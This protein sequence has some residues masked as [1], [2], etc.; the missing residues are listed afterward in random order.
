MWPGWKHVSRGVTSLYTLHKIQRTTSKVTDNVNNAN[1]NGGNG[2]GGNNGCSYK[3]FLACNTQDYD[4]KGGAVA[5]TRWIEKMELV[6]ENSRCAEN[7]KVEFKVLLV[8]EFCP[9]NKMEK[10]E[11][12]FWNHTLVGANHAGYNDRF[13]ELAKLVPHLVTPESKRIGRYISGLAPQI[14]GMLRATQPTTIQSAILKVGILTDEAVCYECG[15]SKHLRNTCP[16]LN[17]APGQAGNRLALEGNRNTQNNRNQARGRV[18]SM[19]A[20]DAL[21]D[22]NI[23]MGTFSLND[24]FA[25]V[26]FDSGADFSFISTKFAPLLNVKPSIVSP[27]YVIE[28]ANGHRSFDVIV[29]IDWLSKNKFEIVCHE[30]VVRIP[31]EGGEILRVQGECTLGGTKTLMSTKADEPELSDI[32]I[33]R[34][35]I[36]VFPKDLWD[37]T[38]TTRACVT[39]AKDSL[40]WVIIS[41]ECMKMISQRLRSTKEDHE[42]HLKLMLELLKKERLYAKFS[43]CEFWLQEV[44]FLRSRDDL[45]LAFALD[46]GTPWEHRSLIPGI[47][48]LRL[49]DATETT[50]DVLV[51]KKTCDVLRGARRIKSSPDEQRTQQQTEPQTG[52]LHDIRTDTTQNPDTKRTIR[53]PYN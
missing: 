38:A 33:V 1:A 27:G 28:V 29:G 45:H 5:L 40:R 8:E 10:L 32:P 23:V 36:D 44:Q 11:S 25:T 19:N 17:R 46:V 42:V 41:L 30:K 50:C 14:R 52:G 51:I 26:L 4:G 49:G 48:M 2:N 20:V 43:K 9:S 13:H 47:A 31:L 34:D 39:S 15:S 3:A 12:E 37:T 16:K 22:P 7:Q 24:H 18:F 35:F 21:H 6:I 53:H